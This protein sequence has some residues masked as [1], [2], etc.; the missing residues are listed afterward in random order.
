MFATSTSPAKYYYPD[1]MVVCDRDP[2]ED[3]YVADPKLIV[4]VLSTST[5]G[6]DRHEKRIAYREITALEEYVIVAQEAIEVTVF[7]R[8]E[9]WQAVV[10][11]SCDSVLE[12][13]SIGLGI[14]LAQVYEGESR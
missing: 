12:L 13:R 2:D 3:R 1:V 7:R 4:E 6:V 11:D 14:P 9:N 8:E 5:A 10:L